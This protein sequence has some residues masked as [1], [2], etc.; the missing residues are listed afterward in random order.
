MTNCTKWQVHGTVGNINAATSANY[1]DLCVVK[2]GAF[3]GAF[4]A[5]TRIQM[6]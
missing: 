2:S 4:G 3:G 5:N 6:L 1:G